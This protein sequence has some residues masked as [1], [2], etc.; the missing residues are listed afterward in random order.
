MAYNFLLKG[1]SYIRGVYPPASVACPSR[2]TK[3]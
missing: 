2:E 1:C 3:T